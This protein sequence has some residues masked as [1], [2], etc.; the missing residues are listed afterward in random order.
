MPQ[1][2]YEARKGPGETSTGV[3]E[4]ESQRAAIARLREMGYF[5]LSVEESDAEEKKDVIREALRRIRLKERNIF[6]RQLASLT[7]SGMILTRALRTL[8]DQTEN[9]KLATLIDQ[10]RDDVQKGSTLAEAMEQHPKVFPALYTSLVRAGETGGM[11]EEVLW[12]IVAFGEQEEEL[13][14]KATSAMVYPIFLLLIGSISIFILI[15]F[16][17]PKFRTVFDQFEARL[18]LPTEIVMAFCD[19]MGVW[20]WAVLLGIFA[21]AGGLVY[22]V[23]TERGRRGWDALLLRIPVIRQVV[24][25]YEMAK[26][27]RTLGTLLDNGV[28]VLTAIRIT[29]E[30]LGNSLIRDEVELVHAGVTEGNAMSD[31]L[32]ESRHFPPMVTSMFAIGEEGGRIGEVSKRVAD[33]Y[34]NEVDRAVKAMTSL[35]EPLLIV[36][37]GVIVGF[38]VIAMLLPMLTLG[39]LVGG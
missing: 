32:R 13:R 23:R 8:V 11:I 39:S 25:K 6:F 3:L 18:P 21:V 33:V 24:L 16:V 14:G 15:S 7:E 29:G 31:I 38:L 28:P 35:F 27:A 19:F 12:R 2:R 22:Y 4:A 34:D 36:I 37:M 5:P 20:W 10:L 26:F 30:T 1:F 17:F 9:R